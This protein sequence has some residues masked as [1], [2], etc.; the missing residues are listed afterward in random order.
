MIAGLALKLLLT[1]VFLVRAAG[2]PDFRVGWA[3]LRRRWR[4]SL[5]MGYTSVMLQLYGTIDQVMLGY[6][7]TAYDAGEYA[8]A[9]R[10]PNALGTFT[11]SWLAVVFPHSAA[12]A[13]GDPQRLRAHSSRLITIV[14]L[15]VVPLVACTPFVAH[16]LIVASFGA[17]YGPASTAFTLLI[18]STGLSILDGTMGTWLMGLGKDRM[19]AR[20]VTVTALL[21]VA[22]NLIAIPTFGR[23]GAAVASIISEVLGFLIAIRGVNAALGGLAPEWGRLGRIVLA[24]CPAILALI[25]VPDS[26]AVWI[27]IPMGAAV[28]SVALVVFGGVATAEI[29]AA[30]GRGKPPTAEA[31]TSP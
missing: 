2:P 4:G 27:R 30:L 28:Y 12:L 26:V 17:Q 22:I 20:L 7:S 18:V 14:A 25:V 1:A 29:R 23:N 24:V 3:A 13:T 11:A 21:N 15:F 8:A 6:F 16:D 19:F 5:T 9:Y 10:I 31:V